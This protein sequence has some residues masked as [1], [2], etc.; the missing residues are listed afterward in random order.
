MSKKE[1][2][3]STSRK[4]DKPWGTTQV[5]SAHGTWQGKIITINAGARTS[6]KYNVLKNEVFYLLSG[7]V[8]I[9]FGNSRTLSDPTINPYVTTILEVG[10]FLSVQ[11]DCPY[12][13]LAIE[14]S[15]LVE[16]ANTQD[17]KTV[18]LEDDYGRGPAGA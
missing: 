2:W 4:E 9:T 14:N 15:V 13:I 18:I 12:R 16:L 11:S 7:L 17:S 6:L 3:K 10:D 5:W 1:I 8:H